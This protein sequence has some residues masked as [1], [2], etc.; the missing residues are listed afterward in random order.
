ML[1]MKRTITLGFL[2]TRLIVNDHQKAD[3]SEQSPE[4]GTMIA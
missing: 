3:L 4:T 2:Q 1:M